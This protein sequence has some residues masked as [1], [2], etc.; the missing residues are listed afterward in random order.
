LSGRSE[1]SCR[2]QFCKI[3]LD[4]ISVHSRLEQQRWAAPELRSRVTRLGALSLGQVFTVGIFFWK[5]P[6]L[7]HNW[8]FKKSFFNIYFSQVRTMTMH[9]KLWQQHC[10]L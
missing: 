7:A 1:V 2:T 8:G 9:T 5:L 3:L 10:N 6:N 4:R